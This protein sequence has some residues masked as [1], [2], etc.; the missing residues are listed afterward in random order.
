[1]NTSSRAAGIAALSVIAGGLI[2]QVS[3]YCFFPSSRSIYGPLQALAEIPGLF[4]NE[5]L[6]SHAIATILRTLGG[7]ILASVLGIVAGAVL[8]NLKPLRYFFMPLVDV[9]RPIPSA[10]LIPVLVLIFGTSPISYYVAIVF[11][12]LWP[13]LLNAC[14]SF[15]RREISTELAIQQLR[16]S[17]LRRFVYIRLPAALPEIVTG[18]R[19]SVAICFILSIT[20]EIIVGRRDGIGFLMTQLDTGGNY[21]GMYGCLVILCVIGFTLN[22]LVASIETRI[23]WLR[24]QYVSVD[25]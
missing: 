9:A 8:G 20:A 14:A 23:P 3:V 25:E 24:N 7:F 13:I 4:R 19:V 18:M 12:G 17:S 1:M 22:H 15:S 6:H 16:L 11:G 10:A 5:S 21:A 2:L